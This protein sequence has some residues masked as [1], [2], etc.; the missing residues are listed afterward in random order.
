MNIEVIKFLEEKIEKSANPFEKELDIV[1][2]NLYK[3]G[4]IDASI[5]DGELFVTITNKGE[6]EYL[7]QVSANFIPAE[8]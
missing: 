4:N 5:V 6:K 1:T 7:E 8:A 2:L 3:E